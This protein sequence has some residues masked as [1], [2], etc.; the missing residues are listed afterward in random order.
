MAIGAYSFDSSGANKG[1]VRVYEFSGSTW[2]QRSGQLIGEAK[3]DNSG[4]STSLS[5]DGNTVAIGAIKNKG[6]STKAGHVRVYRYDGSQWNKL[7]QDIDGSN[8]GD[9]FGGS[10]SLSADGTRL[11]IAANQHEHAGSPGNNSGQIKV[12]ELNGTNWTQLGSYLDG[13]AAGDRAGFSNG[14]TGVSLSGDGTRVAIGAQFHDTASF[15]NAGHARVFA[16]TGVFIAKTGSTDGSGNLLTTEAGASSTFTVVLDAKPTANVTV[17]ISGAD[18]SEHSL[19]A[20]SL[21]F[22]DA[23]WNTA[24]TITVTGVDDSLDDGDITTT[25]TA[26]ASN[27]GGYAGTESATTTVITTDNENPPSITDQSKDVLENTNSGSELLDLSDSNSGNDTDQDGDA[28]TYS[29]TDGNDGGL[30]EIAATTGKISLAANKALNYDTSDLHTLTISATAGIKTVTAKISINVIDVNTAPVAEDDSG[31]VNENETLNT[32]ASTGIIQDNDT[33]TDG[34]S[35]IVTH[36]HAG[37]LNTS[38]PRVGQ[39][40]D[41]LN[42]TF[43]QLTLQTDGSFTYNAN[44]TAADELATGE[45]EVDS[46]S[47]RLSDGKLSDTAELNITVTG[48]NDQPYLVDAI[49]T[50]KYIEGQGNIIVID[51][52]LDIRDIDDDDINSASITISSDTFV[53]TEDL[54]AYA[55]S[56]DITGAWNTTTGV[57]S[58]SGIASKADYVSALQT[59]T[60]KNTN[61]ANP[62]IGLRTIGWLVND[63][64][65]NSPSITSQ[66]D[67]GGRNDSPT[68]INE[69]ASVD[70]G[71]SIATP[72]QANLLANDTDP[73]N[74]SLSITS[75]RL[76]SEQESNPAVTSGSNLTGQYGQMTIQSNGSYTYTAQ[77]AAAYKLLEGETATETFTYTTSDSQDEDTGQITITITGINDAPTAIN[78]TVQVDEDSSKYFDE[79]QGIL[80]NDTDI[81]G[82]QLYIKN[83]R[84]GPDTSSST[85]TSNPSTELQGTYGKLLLQQDGS[86]RYTASLADE[87]DAGDQEI[88]NFT[89]TL[90]DLENEDKA[91]IAINVRGVNDAPSL[92]TIQA[93]TLVDQANSNNLSSTNLAGTLTASDLDESAVLAFGITSVTTQGPTNTTTSSLSATSMTGTYGQLSINSS[94]GAYTYTPNILAANNLLA[95]ETATESFALFVSDGSLSATRNFDI[96]ITGASDAGSPSSSS[97][98]GN[99]SSG[100]SSSINSSSASSPSNSSPSN[101]SSSDSSP[102]NNSSSD[103]SSSDNSSSATAN[104]EASNGNSFIDGFDALIGSL[105]SEPDT[106]SGDFASF[107]T[108]NKS[109]LVASSDIDAITWGPVDSG[110]ESITERL[111]SSD[112]RSIE[113]NNGVRFMIPNFT[114]PNWQQSIPP[115]KEGQIPFLVAL[116]KQPSQETTVALDI[117]HPSINLSSNLVQFTPE[118]WSKGQ[119]VW[120]DMNN[121]DPKEA[122]AII[123]LITNVK[124]EGRTGEDQVDRV[125]ITVPNPKACRLEVCAAPQNQKSEANESEQNLDLELETVRE[126][127]SPLFLLLKT[128]LSPLILLA[129][130]AIHSI[131]QVKHL[132]SPQQSNIDSDGDQQSLHEGGA[133][134]PAKQNNQL[135]QS[136]EPIELFSQNNSSMRP[137]NELPVPS[138][139]HELALLFEHN[140]VFEVF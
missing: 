58:L 98:S 115:D 22:T 59:V 52:S 125:L 139:N 36:F 114:N 89:Y 70:G 103:N 54:L 91:E 88:D 71:S 106:G 77:A 32:T 60:Y 45:S 40:N 28:I 134:A 50:K 27:S 65:V 41:P 113:G 56:A 100:N 121:L 44:K 86:Y 10:V 38:T 13:E 42:G 108:T 8:T 138:L 116:T 83:V 87:L 130:M 55:N 126:V 11:A 119:L 97:S 78:D 94:T 101:S 9:Q 26:T 99:S 128:S 17:A 82:D 93:G 20:S 96:G 109:F 14:G 85:T 68:A 133:S 117:N 95:N 31:T 63:G 104:S 123:Q 131:H 15:N 33:D 107:L 112:F 25:L 46:F 16:T 90:T 12:Y 80:K 79:F 4:W 102:S 69:T 37:D 34:D 92:N 122:N 61:D 129:N 76:G 124:G 29:I 105:N 110:E 135:E 132:Q 51:G 3:N 111:L 127:E 35:L 19:S 57:L 66:I 75:F 23:N 48:I 118:N 81:D 49:K 7:G 72:T 6:N 136:F 74:D 5:A 18:S 1:R 140:N 73:E 67:V 53:S 2:T 137:Q 47:Y 62:V 84:P 39:F 24:Q 30:F 120:I 64:D 21:T 43:G